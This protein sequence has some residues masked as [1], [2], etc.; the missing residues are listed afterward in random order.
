MSK[1]IAAII[2]SLNHNASLENA[3]TSSEKIQQQIRRYNEANR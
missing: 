2:N 1:F 3:L